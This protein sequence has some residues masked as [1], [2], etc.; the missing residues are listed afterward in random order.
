MKLRQK[1][2]ANGQ[3]VNYGNR[4]FYLKYLSEISKYKPLSLEEEV[5]LFDKIKQNGDEK[6]IEKIMKHNLLFVVSVA[7][8]YSVSLNS[9][10]IALEDLINEGNIGLYDAINGYDTNKGFKFISYAVWYIR[11]NILKCL[12]DN[13]KT[14]RLPI[15][16]R[17]EILKIKKKETSLVQMFERPVST[18]EVFEAMLKDGEL[19]QNDTLER[20]DN[21]LK[22]YNFEKSLSSKVTEN[23]DMDLSDMIASDSPSVLENIIHQENKNLIDEMLSELPLKARLFISDFYG[24]NLISP[25][26]I[27]EISEKYDEKPYIVRTTISKYIHWLKRS[28]RKEKDLLT[29]N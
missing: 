1:D 5:V 13:V 7:R 26:S 19:K 28:K 4:D 6:A 24:F 2:S 15:G 3:I 18:V 16:I 9:T 25:L 22:M 29:C 12:S 27:K 23:G 20:F 11:R 10:S 17:N 8:H 14:I 21:I